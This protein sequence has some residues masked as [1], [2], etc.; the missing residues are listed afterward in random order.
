[1]KPA[2]ASLSVPLSTLNPPPPM[3]RFT[4]TK[5]ALSRSIA[6][7][8]RCVGPARSHLHP[9]HIKTAARKST[10]WKLPIGVHRSLTV[11]G[12]KSDLNRDREGAM[13]LAASNGSDPACTDLPA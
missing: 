1:M 11:T 4:R 13:F 3:S 7:D 9:A 6:W 12:L 8:S 2:I 5:V 10:E